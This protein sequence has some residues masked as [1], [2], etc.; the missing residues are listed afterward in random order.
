LYSESLML[1]NSAS[2]YLNIGGIKF[3]FCISLWGGFHGSD[4]TI[5]NSFVHA[6]LEKPI[7]TGKQQV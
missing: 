3:L 2:L 4:F 7:Y 1:L 5:S 6:E